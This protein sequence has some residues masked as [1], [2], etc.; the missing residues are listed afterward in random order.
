[1]FL[2][3][4]GSIFIAILFIVIMCCIETANHL[5]EMYGQKR[6]DKWKK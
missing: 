5:D 3:I 1:M 2:M 6:D 4:V